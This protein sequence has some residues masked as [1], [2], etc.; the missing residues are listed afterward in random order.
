MV[1]ATTRSVIDRAKRIYA[2]RLRATLEPGHIDEYV[3]I[4]PD[5]GEHFIA[6]TLDAA[7]DAAWSRHPDRMSHVIRVGHAAAL[8]MGGATL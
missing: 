5:S 6:D 2:E 1:S 3:A 8:F 4:E 7:V